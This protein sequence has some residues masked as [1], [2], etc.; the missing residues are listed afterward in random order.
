MKVILKSLSGKSLVVDVS[1]TD[2]FV[3]LQAH[4]LQKAGCLLNL[5]HFKY[6]G[7][8]IKAENNV[9]KYFQGGTFSICFGR[10]TCWV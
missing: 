1:P 3:D 2:T 10:S 7:R 5:Q 6:K 4:T 9:M 8:E